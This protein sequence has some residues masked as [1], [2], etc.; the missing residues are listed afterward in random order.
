MKDKMLVAGIGFA[1][2]LTLGACGNSHTPAKNESAQG[3]QETQIEKKN[4]DKPEEKKSE[5]T[6]EK[7]TASVG[8]AVRFGNECGKFYITVD[9]IET[10]SEDARQMADG[11][12]M[13]EGTEYAILL[14]TIRNESYADEENDNYISLQESVY[15][16][17]ANGIS[18]I[19]DNSAFDH[20]QYQGAAGGYFQLQKDQTKRI[21]MYFIVDESQKQITV[22]LGGIKVLVTKNV[23]S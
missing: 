12:D 7:K 16:E 10:G 14:L 22:S 17:D 5:E 19:A 13:P 18:I 2:V 15:L 23:A 11:V 21:A 9:G 6:V 8:E 20:G 1:L 4:D 3:S